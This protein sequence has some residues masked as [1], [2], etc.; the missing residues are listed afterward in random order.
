MYVAIEIALAYGEFKTRHI[1]LQPGFISLKLT[2]ERRGDTYGELG[3]SSG[4]GNFKAEY[5]TQYT[6]KSCQF[7][8][9]GK[10]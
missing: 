5:F 2:P 8:P 1:P 3:K 10:V 6:G 4:N 9:D 7:C